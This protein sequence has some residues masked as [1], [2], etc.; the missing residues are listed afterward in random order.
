MLKFKPDS[1]GFLWKL[2]DPVF[3]NKRAPV[4]L[5]IFQSKILIHVNESLN[6]VC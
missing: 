2:L 4:S 5:F 3:R 6:K 1:S